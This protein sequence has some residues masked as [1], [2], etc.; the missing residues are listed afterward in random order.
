MISNATI[1]DPPLTFSWLD[2]AVFGVMLSVSGIIG[3]FFG[4]FGT[5]QN[6]TDEYLLGGRK[7]HIL[8]VS[9]S[10][11]AS[12]ISGLAVLGVSADIYRYGA[13]H[14]WALIPIAICPL[15]CIYVYMPVFL[16][17]KL[18]TTYQYLQIRFDNTI[19]MLASFIYIFHLII[20]NPVV[21]FL[22]CLAF[23]QATGYNVNVLAPATTIFCVF[24]TAIGG[25]KT[26]VWTDTL[27]TI[28]ILLGLFAVLGM[29][30]YQGGDVSTIFEVA[31]SGERLDI[32]NFNID[33]TIRDNFWTYALGSTAMWMVDVSINQGTLQRLNAV[34]TFAHAK[35]VMLIFF[36]ISVTVKV[37]AIITG[38]SM[39]ARYADCD[40]LLSG[41]VAHSD[42]VVPYYVM[43]VGG[44]ILGLPGLFIAGVFAAALSTLSTN[45]L[46]LS[47]TIYTDLLSGFV[48]K[49]IS[50]RNVSYI[51]KLIVAVV[52]IVDCGLVL[53]VGKFGG[54]LQFGISL[55]G[56]TYGTLLGLFTLGMVFPIANKQGALCGG[57]AGIIFSSCMVLGN[58][59]YK[60]HGTLPD[61]PKPVSTRGCNF[62]TPLLM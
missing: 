34:P 41:K 14:V 32:F 16:K 22:P 19:K 53:I 60:F 5:K 29:G 54:I 42:Q 24:Y 7:L 13:A 39:Y 37:L 27:Q 38:I 49:S 62:T 28:S 8:P 17:L 50:E 57:I 25:L 3:I 2:Y 44:S 61:Y 59:W 52:G 18:I 35:M 12:N 51:L 48:S 45:L 43:D 58:L 15:A 36:V 46:N 30:L 56:I 26:V 40:P 11:I 4:C 20:Y 31:K 6:S 47:T 33:P 23:N 9:M 55:L 10:I 21:I 1:I